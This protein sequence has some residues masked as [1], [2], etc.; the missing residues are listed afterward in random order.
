SPSPSPSKKT[1]TW[2][3][4]N[5]NATV[6]CYIGETT[7]DVSISGDVPSPTG[8]NGIWTTL[9][10]DGKTTIISYQGQ[11]ST[12]HIAMSYDDQVGAIR[13]GGPTT[14]KASNTTTYG[15]ELNVYYA[16]YTD[17]MPSL[18]NSIGNVS[19]AIDS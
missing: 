2:S 7:F 10:G 8:D 19:F 12:P 1:Y 4:T 6:S 11:A 18:S 13:S 16:P 14:L 17:G 9:T 15:Y 5:V 3:G